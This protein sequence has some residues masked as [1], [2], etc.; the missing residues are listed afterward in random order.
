M[1]TSSD[2]LRVLIVDDHLAWCSTLRF[3]L[4]I[5]FPNI[6]IVGEASNG[7]SAIELCD[8]TK[9]DLV[10]LDINMPGMNGFETAKVLLANHPDLQII[11]V[12]AEVN[13]KHDQLAKEAGFSS[14]F[15]KDMLMDHLPLTNFHPHTVASSDNKTLNL[16]ST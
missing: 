16:G 2:Q 10:L 1:S 9:P 11:G 4:M 15:P 3:C 12:S 13:P 7:Q 5:T 14:V 6:N 8:L